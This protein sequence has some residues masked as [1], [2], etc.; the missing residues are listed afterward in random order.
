MRLHPFG[1][2]SEEELR[3]ASEVL[4]WL[5][6]HKDIQGIIFKLSHCFA[7]LFCH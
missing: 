6:W 4:P 3:E 5:L 2:A 7:L 1:N